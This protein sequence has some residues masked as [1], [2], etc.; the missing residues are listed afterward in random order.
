MTCIVCLFVPLFAHAISISPTRQTITIDKGTTQTLSIEVEN[1]ENSEL[2][3]APTVY[4]FFLEEK[5]GALQLS[6]HDDS[7]SWI[8]VKKEAI[9]IPPNEKVLVPYT[10]TIPNDAKPGAYYFVLFAQKKANN[11]TINV[12]SQVGSLLFLYVAGNIEESLH[13]AD[14]NTNH[15][16]YFAP[17]IEATVTFKNSGTIHVVPQ[18]ELTVKNARGNTITT[19]SLGENTEKILAGG[20]RINTY[21]IKNISWKDIGPL[22]I[23]V[24]GTYGVSK[25]TYKRWVHVWYVPKEIIIGGLAFGIVLGIGIYVWWYLYAKKK[26][27]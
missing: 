27:T 19:M 3:V 10:I 9:Q 17:N 7:L 4:T 26:Q 22:Y 12:V 24:A 20:T 15:R 23:E 18:G 25:Q 13:I 8:Q 5:T 21:H 2:V 6:E 16:W 11:S 1:N 14:V